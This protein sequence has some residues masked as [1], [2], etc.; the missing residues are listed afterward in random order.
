MFWMLFF[1]LFVVKQRPLKKHKTSTAK[2]KILFE[3]KQNRNWK[4]MKWSCWVK[5]KEI[6]GDRNILTYWQEF[7]CDSDHSL[8]CSIEDDPPPQKKNELSQNGVAPKQEQLTQTDNQVSSPQLQ[9]FYTFGN[10][11]AIWPKRWQRKR[12]WCSFQLIIVEIMNVN[13]QLCSQLWCKD[14]LLGR[15]AW[16]S[17]FEFESWQGKCGLELWEACC[18]PQRWRLE[19]TSVIYLCCCRLFDFG[20]CLIFSTKHRRRWSHVGIQQRE[21]KCGRVIGDADVGADA[22][23]ELNQFESSVDKHGEAPVC[24]QENGEQLSDP[25][26]NSISKPELSGLEDNQN[27]AFQDSA[28]TSVDGK[29]SHACWCQ[30][31]RLYEQRNNETDMSQK[32]LDKKE[33]DDVSNMTNT[34]A[35]LSPQQ[36]SQ[37]ENADD[38]ESMLSLASPM[39]AKQ[40]AIPFPKCLSS[41]STESDIVSSSQSP[42][43]PLATLQPLPETEKVVVFET[44]FS[45]LSF[46][47]QNQIN[48]D[49]IASNNPNN[50]TNNNPNNIANNNPN[51]IAN[52]NPNIAN[53]NPR[54]V[55]TNCH[56]NTDS[57]ILN[58][59]DF[60]GNTTATSKAKFKNTRCN[61]NDKGNFDRNPKSQNNSGNQTIPEVKTI[62]E[63]EGM[64]SVQIT[65]MSFTK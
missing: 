16:H 37:I 39:A 54:N 19:K 47:D 44:T 50:I 8:S 12:C 34:T 49:H 4:K 15:W 35:I 63:T 22:G 45:D 23:D 60:L 43:T 41:E 2:Q 30:T 65:Q 18:S 38:D 14:L 40:Q 32:F 28:A 62:P 33:N 17:R 1:V 13:L 10:S 9:D 56:I 55:N 64:I 57:S 25:T 26:F 31:W 11:T 52:N 59:T 29:A 27:A 61:V 20:F 58:Q 46:D 24:K 3:E 7:F 53:N 5:K 48:A 6:V 36:T 42:K 21:H 51:N